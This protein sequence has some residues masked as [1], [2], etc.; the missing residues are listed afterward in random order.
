ME[1]FFLNLGK[2]PIQNFPLYKAMRANQMCARMT[3]LV[4]TFFGRDSPP[5]KQLVISG[6]SNPQAEV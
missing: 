2:K 5:A 6:D 1:K 3:P 4:K